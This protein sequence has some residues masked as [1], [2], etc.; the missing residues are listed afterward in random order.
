MFNKEKHW[1]YIPIANSLIPSEKV[2]VKQE[3]FEMNKKYL[4]LLEG[5]CAI[6]RTKQ[7]I[8]KLCY[9]EEV[10]QLDDEITKTN[11]NKP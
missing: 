5:L 11:M 8:Y 7:F 10:R 1:C 9:G 2:S 3:G 4:K 6:Y